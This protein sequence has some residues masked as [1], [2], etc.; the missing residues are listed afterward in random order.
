MTITSDRIWEMARGF[1]TSRVLLTGVELNIFAAVGD[2]T[3][4]STDVAKEIGADRRATD[5]LM[6][7]L[8]GI[9]LLAKENGGFRN[10]P[11]TAAILVPGKP[12]FVG[13][14]LFPIYLNS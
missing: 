11:E 3:M 13:P 1:Q 5:R 12:G 8:V 14:A 10:T 6:N 9:E 4:T 2:V 7:A